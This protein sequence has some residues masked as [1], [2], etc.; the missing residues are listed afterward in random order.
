MCQVK[1][2]TCDFGKKTDILHMA[3]SHCCHVPGCVAPF[4]WI[5]PQVRRKE[6]FAGD[7]AD[8]IYVRDA[9]TGGRAIR[10]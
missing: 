1:D 4:E 5:G 7:K 10:S 3:A 6:I 9:D 8:T 2:L